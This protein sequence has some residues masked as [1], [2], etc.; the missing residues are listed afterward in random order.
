[1]KTALLMSDNGTCVHCGKVNTLKIPFAYRNKV[2]P[3]K[4]R[5]GY[6]TRCDDCGMKFH[7]DPN[8]IH[9]LP[10]GHIVKE[11]NGNV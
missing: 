3:Y 2:S 9:V 8:E 11:V 10:K 6:Y 7:H 1:M 4:R 5:I